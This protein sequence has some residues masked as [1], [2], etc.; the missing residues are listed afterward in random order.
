MCTKFYK[1]QGKI[2]PFIVEAVCK[3]VARK[4]TKQGKITPSIVEAICCTKFYRAGENNTLTLFHLGSGMT[5]SP[6]G[7]QI[8][9]HMFYA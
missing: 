5:L 1:E 7:G 4:T 2:T 8:I 3:Y 9:P 6:G